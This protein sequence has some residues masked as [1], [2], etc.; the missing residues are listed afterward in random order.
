MRRRR[1]FTYYFLFAVHISFEERKSLTR[2]SGF[3]NMKFATCTINL[4]STQKSFI[5]SLF[6]KL[7][8]ELV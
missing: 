2:P 6:S 1:P 3:I 7:V 5:S 4:N 8:A